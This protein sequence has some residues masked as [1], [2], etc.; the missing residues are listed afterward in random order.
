ME[1]Q[2]QRGKGPFS[3]VGEFYPSHTCMGPHCSKP[4]SLEV[5]SP[6]PTTM[7]PVTSLGE[8][9][10]A[11]KGDALITSLPLLS[12][13]PPTVVSPCAGALG[14][15]RPFPVT[16]TEAGDWGMGRKRKETPLAYRPG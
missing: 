16:V 6:N 8:M 15:A 13:V 2:E 14:L 5:S 3:V 1:C 12:L 4:L 11:P 10:T 9:P 7:A